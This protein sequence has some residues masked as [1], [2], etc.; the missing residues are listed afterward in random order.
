[1]C[2]VIQSMH[3]KISLKFN[4]AN[5]ALVNT[6]LGKLPQH[7]DCRLYSGLYNDMAAKPNSNALSVDSWNAWT[8]SISRVCGHSPE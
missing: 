5:T 8:A 2:S 4:T 7:F 3:C 6:Y 1:M